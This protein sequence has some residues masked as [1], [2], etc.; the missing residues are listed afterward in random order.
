M[1]I[2]VKIIILIP[3][4]FVAIC[5]LRL[6]FKAIIELGSFLGAFLRDFFNR[7]KR[8][9]NKKRK[10][11]SQIENKYKRAIPRIIKDKWNSDS[12][13]RLSEEQLDDLLI[14]SEHELSQIEEKV[15]AEEQVN[16]EKQRRLDELRNKYPFAYAYYMREVSRSDS[17]R[18]E[19]NRL[20]DLLS[21]PVAEWA[22]KEGEIVESAIKLD[23][24]RILGRQYPLAVASLL[25]A[26]RFSI[27]D[28]LYKNPDKV[29]Y[30]L[31]IPNA[32]LLRIESEIKERPSFVKTV[33][34]EEEKR[35]LYELS[36]E[37]KENFEEYQKYLD[38]RNVKY[39]Y[40]FT[41]RSNLESIRTNGGLFSWKYSEEHDIVVPKP[42]GSCLSRELDELYGLEDYVRLSF[43][44][45]HP[46]V[47]RLKT[48]E[49]YRM[50]L[51]V[52][53]A[54]V[55]LLKYTMFSDM[56]A[57]DKGHT[58]GDS[59]KHLKNVKLYET[60]REP[61]DYLTIGGSKKYWQ[62]EV[63]VKTFVPLEYIVNIDKPRPL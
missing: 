54:E 28:V 17:I 58:H 9:L 42:G 62:A 49:R 2:V 59:L 41:E 31:S 63:L 52:I 46:M 16:F 20:E 12:I 38:R 29:D 55:A 53:K 3:I 1:D 6:L 11:V 30:L 5:L 22:L 4:I 27:N 13:Y 50:V 15:I 8:R 23:K 36:H 57:A 10:R 60:N 45:N 56:N 44:R 61:E 7:R 48:E 24:A 35:Y 19:N 43:T 39:L 51:L 25:N 34:D 14:V 40:H 32:E 26:G 33:I 18:F 21:I 47:Y 37:K